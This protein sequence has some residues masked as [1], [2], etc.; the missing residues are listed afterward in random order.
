[1]TAMGAKILS[2]DIDIN[3]DQLRLPGFTIQ[4]ISPLDPSGWG[5]VN[6]VRAGG[7]PPWQTRSAGRPARPDPRPG[8]PRKYDAEPNRAPAATPPEATGSTEPA[9]GTT[10]V[11]VGSR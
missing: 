1:M 11:A 10:P 3:L 8:G 7:T 6:L 5:R 9:A 2:Q 4:S